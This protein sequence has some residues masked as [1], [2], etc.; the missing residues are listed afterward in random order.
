MTNYKMILEYDGTRYKGWQVQGNTQETIQGKLEAVLGRMCGETIEIHGSGR[1]DGGVHAY[2]QVANFKWKQEK[3]P[4]AI[5]EYLNRY[6]PEDIR[7][8]SVEVAEERFHSRLNA[9]DKTYRYRIWKGGR[10]DVF[11][12]R[13]VEPVE[14]QLDT[15]RMREAASY[16]T[17]THDFTSFCGNKHFKKSAV[18][19][20]YDIQIEETK[21]EIIIDIRGDGFLQNMIRILVGTLVETGKGVREPQDMTAVL[22]G[23]NRALAGHM[24]APGGLALME[25]RYR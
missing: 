5:S 21:D 18:R 1:T 16:L 14:E 6:L 2:G 7:I 20:I 3:N 9:V 10:P 11:A 4:E 8:L 17:G 22:E 24:M 15:A 23:K 19:T 13:Y 25:V 12:R